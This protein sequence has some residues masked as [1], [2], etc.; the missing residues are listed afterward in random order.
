MQF[1]KWISATDPNPKHCIIYR[2]QSLEEKKT[3]FSL[4]SLLLA[5]SSYVDHTAFQLCG[6]HQNY[7]SP[8]LPFLCETWTAEKVLP[9]LCSFPTKSN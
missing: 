6:L 7:L 4:A 9:I 2:K 3:S 1:S 5:T 8:V